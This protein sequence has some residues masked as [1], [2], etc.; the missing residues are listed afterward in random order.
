MEISFKCGYGVSRLTHLVRLSSAAL[1]LPLSS[2]I[3]GIIPDMRFSSLGRRRAEPRL[4]H[5]GKFMGA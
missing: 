4:E 1:D 2:G 3:P 5:K